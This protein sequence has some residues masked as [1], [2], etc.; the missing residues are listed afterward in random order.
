MP[1]AKTINHKPIGAI[2]LCSFYKASAVQCRLE[3]IDTRQS[4][5]TFTRW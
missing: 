1:A 4:P 2:S 3:N 5:E